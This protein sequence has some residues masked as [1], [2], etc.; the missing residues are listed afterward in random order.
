MVGVFES[1]GL[2]ELVLYQDPQ[3]AL[4]KKMGNFD[5]ADIQKSQ[6]RAQGKDNETVTISSISIQIGR[7]LKARTNTAY[8]PGINIA[9]A[10][11][12]STTSLLT[13]EDAE[14]EHALLLGIS[15]L[16]LDSAGDDI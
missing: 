1:I 16:A 12:P 15:S 7:K 14:Y 11:Y 3:A 2:T 8:P 5:E 4:K 6:T 13:Q 10:K 9:P